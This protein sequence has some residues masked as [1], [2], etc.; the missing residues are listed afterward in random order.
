MPDNSTGNPTCFSFGVSLPIVEYWACMESKGCGEK[1]G[2][3]NMWGGRIYHLAARST[4]SMLD[5]WR[6][7][8]RRRSTRGG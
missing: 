4:N 6:R 1:A 2:K 3:I 5:V 7:R 8:R